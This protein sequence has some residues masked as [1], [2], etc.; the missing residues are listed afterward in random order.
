MESEAKRLEPAK[1]APVQSGEFKVELK[2][3]IQGDIF[4]VSLVA[5]QKFGAPLYHALWARSLDPRL[6]TDVQP[7]YPSKLEETGFFRKKL[8]ITNED[9]CTYSFHVGTGSLTSVSCTKPQA[10]RDAFWISHGETHQYKDRKITFVDLVSDSRCPTD[11]DCEQ[12]GEAVVKL[13]ISDSKK[14]RVL[15]LT[16]LPTKEDSEWKLIEVSPFPVTVKRK[17]AKKDYKILLL[18]K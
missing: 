2:D 6:E 16:T 15:T 18:R 12:L 3:E 7:N 9:G 10:D 5:V 14:S 4:K 13:E 8:L 17:N 1:I 11:C